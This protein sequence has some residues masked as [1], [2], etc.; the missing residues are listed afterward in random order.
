MMAKL[1]HDSVTDAAAAFAAERLAGARRRSLGRGDPGTAGRAYV[2]PG[3][4]EAAALLC[5]L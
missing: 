3:T 5:Q 2:T 4:G 1:E